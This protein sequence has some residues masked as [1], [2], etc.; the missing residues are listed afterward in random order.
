MP[1]RWLAYLSLAGW[2]GV[3]FWFSSQPD[4]SSGL[5][6]WKDWV[7]RKVAHLAEFFVLTYFWLR[8]F[9]AH[10]RWQ[11]HQATAAA[12]F[13]LAIAS[14]DELYQATVPGRH[15]SPID[16]LVDVL[17]A[18]IFLVLRWRYPR[19]DRRRLRDENKNTILRSMRL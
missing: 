9:S 19:P 3:I 14:A 11:P 5:E 8:C 10:R 16:V 2:V 4:L 13:A 18:T 7:L 17:G 6:T 1:R 15:G 12:A